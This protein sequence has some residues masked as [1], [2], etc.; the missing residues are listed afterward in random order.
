MGESG[1]RWSHAVRSAHKR[2]QSVIG[3]PEESFS[4]GMSLRTQPKVGYGSL[5][6]WLLFLLTVAPVSGVEAAG[7]RAP[8][9]SQAADRATPSN[10]GPEGCAQ[11]IGYDRSKLERT[12]GDPDLELRLARSLALCGQY[13]EALARYR[14]VLESRP[15]DENTLSEMAHALRRAGRDAFSGV[16][17]IS[18]VEAE[19][20]LRP[21][22][23]PDMMSEEAKAA[24]GFF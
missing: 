2:D 14:Q 7:R 1:S 5:R 8:A 15:E 9:P 16:E 6:A 19:M 12:P 3:H 11:R 24:L 22:W 18:Q 21:P 10:T 23:T 13:A 17:G 20:V 4:A